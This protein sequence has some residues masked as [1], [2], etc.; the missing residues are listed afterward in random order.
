[1]SGAGKS[2]RKR[3]SRA[4]GVP[5]G[6]TRLPPE[7]TETRVVREEVVV[8][9]ESGPGPREGTPDIQRGAV[10]QTPEPSVGVCLRA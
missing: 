5:T 9:V 2:G 8:E 7:E 6:K 4:R 1:M 10:P 3:E